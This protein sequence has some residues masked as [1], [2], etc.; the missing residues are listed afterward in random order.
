MMR[1]CSRRFGSCVCYGLLCSLLLSDPIGVC[2]CLRNTLLQLLNPL[3][4]CPGDMPQP[5]QKLFVTYL[6]PIITSSHLESQK[7]HTMLCVTCPSPSGSHEAGSLLC[8]ASCDTGN[9]FT[10]AIRT[11]NDK[12]D[13]QLS[14]IACITCVGSHIGT[15]CCY[16]AQI[17]QPPA[18][19]MQLL[20]G[21]CPSQASDQLRNEIKP[22]N[23]SLNDRVK[24]H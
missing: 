23:T 9:S 14:E 21:Q 15:P 18:R 17:Y 12:W 19:Q 1:C 5:T 16:S 7:T 4:V 11:W 3:W 22:S 2:V 24:Q 6:H 10:L 20:Y 13:S 8:A